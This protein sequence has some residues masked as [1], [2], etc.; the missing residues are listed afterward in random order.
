MSLGVKDRGLGLAR[1]LPRMALAAGLLTFPA[2]ATDWPEHPNLV[3]LV[4]DTLR[5]DHLGSYGYP[6]PITPNLDRFA[7]ESIQFDHCFS[8]APW[9]KPAM[10]SLFT[11]L[12]AHVHGQT[13]H[14]GKYWG[15][16]SPEMRTGVLPDSA[17]TL[18]ELLREHGYRTAGFVAN[19]WLAARYGFAQGFDHFDD[20]EALRFPVAT[21]LIDRAQSWL[22]GIGASEPYFLF[23]HFMD[24][25]APYDATQEDYE[26]MRVD[27]ERRRLSEDEVPYNRWQ[28]IEVRPE[29]AGDDTRH[30]VDYWRARY[31]SGVR[32]FDRRLSTFL[33]RLREEGQLDRSYVI[34][35]SDHGEEL[36]EHGDWSHGQN[37]HDHQ[38]HVPLLIRQPGGRQQGT[39]VGDLTEL[40][41]VM[42]T[43]LALAGI[44]VPPSLQGRALLPLGRGSE[45]EPAVAYATATQNRPGLHAVRTHRHKLVLDLDSN[46]GMLFDLAADPAELQDVTALSWGTANRLRERLL[47]HIATSLEAGSFEAETNVLPDKVQ[48]RLKALGYLN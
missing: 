4:V 26:L 42:P 18:A 6:A 7:A 39:R 25:H 3:L 2:C 22:E 23:L 29:W 30:E 24:V 16:D 1:K 14:E 43:I 31:A 21:V 36:F 47:D 9:T 11:S 38:L 27:G 19:P 46:A 20:G 41:D 35:T 37:L 10:A 40:V 28:N 8:Q 44:E 33:D 32:A 17:V 5:A 45:T 48:E 15:G 34:L 13:N 12:Y